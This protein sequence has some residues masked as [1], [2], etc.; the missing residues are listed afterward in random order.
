MLLGAQT[1]VVIDFMVTTD[2]IL[3]TVDCRSSDTR[4]TTFSNFN[5]KKISVENC[6]IYTKILF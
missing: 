4:V 5:T 3:F 6:D 1:G 2:S